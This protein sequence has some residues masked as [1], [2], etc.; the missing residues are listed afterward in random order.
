M[1]D[2]F[3]TAAELAMLIGSSDQDDLSREQLLLAM[4]SGMVRA[5]CHQ[6]LSPVVDDVVTV[7]PTVSTLLTLPERPVTAVSQV[8]VDGVATTNYYVRPRGIRSGTVAS[9]G[10]AWLSGATVTY[11]H[12]YAETT[13]EYKTIKSVCL[14]MASRA[15]TMNQNGASLALGSSVLE[16]AG[17]GPEIFLTPGEKETLRRF[18]RG[19]V[20]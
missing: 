14:S 11:S 15:F 17:F 12:G 4:A 18:K 13:A 3:A 6:E 16:T 1:A 20:R 9:P 2:S 8:L 7:Y 19:P 5:Y 10:S